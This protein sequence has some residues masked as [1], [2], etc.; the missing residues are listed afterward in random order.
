MEKGVLIYAETQEGKL[1]PITAELL[2]A[3][4]KLADSLG[5]ELSA[6]LVG[7]NVS[8][9]APEVIAQGAQ[10]VYVV[11]DPLLK[12]YQS[13]AYVMATEQALNQIQPQILLMG[14]TE[15]G[16][17]LA[18]RL[19]FRLK[20]SASMDCIELSIQPETKLLLQNRPVYG[21]NARATLS[22]PTKPQI[23]TVRAKAMEP[24]PKDPSR[25]GETV[26]VKVELDATKVRAKVLKRVKEEVAGVKLEEAGVVIGGGRGI[27]GAEGFKQLEELS[28]L[29][30][31]AVGA[32]RPP[33]D[34]NWL[35][36][37][38]QIGLTG[39]IIT[40]ELY[41][42]VALSGSS[43]HMAGCSGAK[44]IVAINKDPD[45]NIF[46]EARFG[47]IGDWKQVVPAFTEKVKE[48]LST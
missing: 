47:I 13:D 16:R 3:G 14:Q 25:Q 31:G 20:T 1:A 35:P 21:G 18:P 24:L 30:K 8:L 23:A 12:E 9:L 6:I 39:K 2:G 40:P 7:S 42:A 37:S 43:Q 22:I 28:K 5:E 41:I 34:N 11:D 4:R 29:F 10:K 33:V 27:N 46:K 17:D 48:L 45:A 19:A 32:S 26:P 15:I 38:Q 44:T 36:S